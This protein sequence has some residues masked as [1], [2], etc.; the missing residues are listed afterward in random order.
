VNSPLLSLCCPCGAVHRSGIGIRPPLVSR[1]QSP[2]C[3]PALSNPTKLTFSPASFEA[4]DAE[5]RVG[6]GL[7]ARYNAI[8]GP[9]YIEVWSPWVNGGICMECR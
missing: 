6:R 8:C 7:N 3:R 2:N 4:A 5:H 1:A 9:L